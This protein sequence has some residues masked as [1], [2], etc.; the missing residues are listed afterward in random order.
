MEGRSHDWSNNPLDV[1]ALV[2][3]YMHSKALQQPPLLVLPFSQ[4]GNVAALAPTSLKPEHEID[5]KRERE[6]RKFAAMFRNPREQLHFHLAANYYEELLA[7]VAKPIPN[8]AF[9]VGTPTWATCFTKAEQTENKERPR[10]FF[11]IILLDP[12]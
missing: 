1:C 3:Q 4:V 8:S 9:L 6:L 11:S 5:E 12:T 10:R 2:K 7:A